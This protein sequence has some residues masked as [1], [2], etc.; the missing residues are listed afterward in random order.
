MRLLNDHRHMTGWFVGVCTNTTVN[1]SANLLLLI[2]GVTDTAIHGEL[3]LSGDLDGGGP[4]YGRIRGGTIAFMTCI[5]AQQVVIE[6]RSDISETGYSGT[7]QATSDHPE[8]VAAGLQHQEGV[9]SCS[10]VRALGQ[11]TPERDGLVWLFDEGVAEGPLPVDEFAMHA[12]AGRWPGR[13]LVALEDRDQP[14]NT[15]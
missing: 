3:K 8:I 7:Y 15:T 9:W 12:A 5:P 13:T 2:H 11:A 14:A 10:F 4:F 6:W 1:L